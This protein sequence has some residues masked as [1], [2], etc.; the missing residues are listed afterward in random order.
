MNELVEKH[1]PEPRDK[2]LRGF[3]WYHWF[4]AGRLYT[5]EY[6]LGWPLRGLELSPAGFVS[7][8]SAGKNWISVG[9]SPAGRARIDTIDTELAPVSF[10]PDGASL[11]IG[12][13]LRGRIRVHDVAGKTNRTYP[14]PRD[15]DIRCLAFSSTGETMATGGRGGRIVLWDTASW[16]PKGTTM[17]TDGIVSGLAFA[18]DGKTLLAAME[19]STVVVWDVA[20]GASLSIQRTLIGHGKQVSS[21]VTCPGAELFATGRRT[22]NAFLRGPPAITVSWSGTS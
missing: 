4:Q 20:E 22:G 8:I 9:N 15:H 14:T 1:W 10:M 5:A 18:L 3:E 11:V 17:P 13:S 7:A 19:N 12:E 16:K 2:D 21:V 6:S